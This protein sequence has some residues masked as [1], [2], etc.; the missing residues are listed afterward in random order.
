MTTAQLPLT[1]LELK[2]QG[3]RSVSRHN[4]VNMARV[5]AEGFCRGRGICTTDDLHDVMGTPPR[6]NCYGAIFHDK[7]FVWTG[8]YVKST[9][10]EAHGRVIKVWALASRR[11]YGEKYGMTNS[12]RTG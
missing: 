4:W 1:G 6:P 10:R 2:E 7:R 5:W 11:T 3:I 12:E 9:R 8:R